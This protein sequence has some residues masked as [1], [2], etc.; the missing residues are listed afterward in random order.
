MA[1]VDPD[2]DPHIAAAQA[3]V[4]ALK[5]KLARQKELQQRGGGI[6]EELL[7]MRDAGAPDARIVAAQARADALE[8]QLVDQAAA[9]AEAQARAAAAAATTT[10]TTTARAAPPAVLL[11]AAAALPALPFQRLDSNPRRPARNSGF[12]LPRTSTKDDAYVPPK[13]KNLDSFRAAFAKMR[14][15]MTSKSSN[16]RKASEM[17]DAGNAA[18]GAKGE[19][20]ELKE[21]D[22]DKIPLPLAT[23]N[24]DIFSNMIYRGK[25]DLKEED[26]TVTGMYSINEKSAV[27][28]KIRQR[29]AELILYREVEAA[30]GEAAAAMAA[31]AATGVPGTQPAR[32]KKGWTPEQEQTIAELK[33]QKAEL[34]EKLARH[35]AAKSTE[36]AAAALEAKPGYGGG[37]LL[38]P[39]L[40][41]A[42]IDTS[43]GA[44]KA[45]VDSS[46]EGD[47]AQDA[48][49]GAE[50]SNEALGAASSLLDLM[51]RVAKKE[52]GFDSEGQEEPENQ[53]KRSADELTAVSATDQDRLSS[54]SEN[55]MMAD[56]QTMG[57]RKKARRLTPPGTETPANGLVNVGGEKKSGDEANTAADDTSSN[58]THIDVVVVTEE[59][60]PNGSSN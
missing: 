29:Q 38:P 25:I 36:K 32:R 58:M 40:P 15:N 57:K 8:K 2:V 34:D 24:G 60:E 39:I 20:E 10:A 59:S 50:V 43:T 47:S 46:V 16:K 14:T 9:K 52:S 28:Q 31:A 27:V 17:S 6:A 5:K 56:L 41:N 18:D 42:A 55:K 3:R 7:Y 1:S 45:S 4:D 48:N 53:K 33:K 12:P 26:W 13:I 35:Q 49:K 22:D 23:F 54:S 30:K 19:S 37:S 51:P 21:D 11:A 44:P